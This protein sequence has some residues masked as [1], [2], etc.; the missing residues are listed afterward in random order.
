[1][2][3]KEVN[4]PMSKCRLLELFNAKNFIPPYECVVNSSEEDTVSFFKDHQLKI[5]KSDKKGQKTIIEF[6]EPED[7][8]KALLL[9]GNGKM[10]LLNFKKSV[11]FD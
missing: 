7:L 9:N 4:Y 6:D 3:D 8:K 10:I 2:E 5:K 11:C 1:M